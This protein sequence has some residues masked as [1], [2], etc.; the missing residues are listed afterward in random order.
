[1][2][3]SRYDLRV[4]KIEFGLI[5]H[6]TVQV[7]RAHKYTYKENKEKNHNIVKLGIDVGK[8]THAPVR[9][10]AIPMVNFLVLWIQR[11]Y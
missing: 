6:C 3:T 8:I 2:Y 4:N 5:D 10:W 1:M 7:Q 9:K 11:S